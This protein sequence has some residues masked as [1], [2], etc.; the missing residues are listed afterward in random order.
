[1]FSLLINLAV[2]CIACILRPIRAIYEMPYDLFMRCIDFVSCFPGQV[3]LVGLFPVKD[4]IKLRWV[5]SVW[6][7]MPVAKHEVCRNNWWFIGLLKRIVI[8]IDW[9]PT[10]NWQGIRERIPSHSIFNNINYGQTKALLRVYDIKTS[11]IY[12]YN[13]VFTRITTVEHFN[14]PSIPVVS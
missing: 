13:R 12:W 4:M 11:W 5:A 10:M 6:Y 9:A 8:K 1:M 7:K 3:S 2:L 14:Q